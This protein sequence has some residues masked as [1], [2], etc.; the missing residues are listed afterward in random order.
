MNTAK[1]AE[2]LHVD[3]VEIHHGKLGYAVY[4]RAGSQRMM[5]TVGYDAI[6]KSVD[7]EKPIH[8]VA[9]T[10]LSLSDTLLGKSRANVEATNAALRAE[11]ESVQ[12]FASRRL[13]EDRGR[14]IQRYEPALSKALPSRFHAIVEE[15]S[16]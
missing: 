8:A 3:D 4:V 9:K 2:L 5:S 14:Q 1:I 7:A 6:A 13:Y 16:R 10:L 15:L 12:R 11:A